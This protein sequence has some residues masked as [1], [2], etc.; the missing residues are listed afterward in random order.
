MRLLLAT[1]L[2]CVLAAAPAVAQ[3]AK[4][5]TK[6]PLS[7]H[8]RQGLGRATPTP[9]ATSTP[10]ATPTAGP[11]RNL[12]NTGADPMRLALA[13]LTLLGFGLSLRFR[14]ALADA[15]RPD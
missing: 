9:T 2:A 10:R 7:A 12:P 11:R 1:L 5:F 15:R 4:P 3:G 14:V 6:P 13:G 8:P